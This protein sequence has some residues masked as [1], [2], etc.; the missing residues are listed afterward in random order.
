MMNE[1][2][3]ICAIEKPQRMADLSDWPPNINEMVPNTLCPTIMV[4]TRQRIGM[5]YSTRIFGSTS[6]PTD[7]KNTAPKRFLTGSTS[8]SIRSASMVSARML[9]MIKAPKAELKPTL[10]ENTAMA[11][12]KPKA[13]MSSTSLLMS[14]R[15][16]RRYRGMAKIPTTSHSIRKK[17]IRMTDCKS[18]PPPIS[19][20]LA[21][22][23]SIT[24]MTMARISSSISTLITMPANCC[25][26][27]PRSSKAL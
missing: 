7:T 13:T 8:F 14:R 27:N 1:N 11:Q 2:S 10:V 5:A 18:C 26:R 15:T 4:S 20:P 21:R 23:L 22:A 25:W 12:H 16:R 17:P 19:E 9:P 24:I 6:I 3:P